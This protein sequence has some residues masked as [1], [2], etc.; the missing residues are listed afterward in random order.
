M[1]KPSLPQAKICTD[2]TIPPRTKRC[3]STTS[4]ITTEEREILPEDAKKRFQQTS[5]GPPPHPCRHEGSSQQPIN[6]IRKNPSE[7]TG[8]PLMQSFIYLNI[9]SRMIWPIGLI[10]QRYP[11]SCPNASPPHCR[12]DTS[13]SARTRTHTHPARRTFHTLRSTSRGY[14][15]RC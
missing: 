7:P 8:H 10:D 6:P 14:P 1:E 12:K 11:S 9:N 5:L 3:R 13:W 4:K 2:Q 15:G